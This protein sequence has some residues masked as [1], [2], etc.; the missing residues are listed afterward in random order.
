MRRKHGFGYPPCVRHEV[1]CPLCRFGFDLFAAR[2]C[3]HSGESSKVCPSCR[4]CVCLLPE[5]REP[6]L[7]KQAPLAFR[8]RGFRRLFVHYL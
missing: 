8:K 4:S 7:W 5:Y 3:E 1:R 2:W 6:K